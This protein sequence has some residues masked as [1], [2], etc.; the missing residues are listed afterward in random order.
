MCIL[1]YACEKDQESI[2]TQS[3]LY[4][5]D[6]E[7]DKI[8]IIKTDRETSSSKNQRK[9]L[10]S[11]SNYQPQVSGC[12]V[13]YPVLF[14]EPAFWDFGDGTSSSASSSGFVHTYSGNGT[15]SISSSSGARFTVIID[16]CNGG[17]T[18][19]I[20]VVHHTQQGNCFYNAEGIYSPNGMTQTYKI[21]GLIPSSVSNISF[22]LFND[23]YVRSF[24]PYQM[25]GTYFFD[26]I[27][28]GYP[29]LR[30]RGNIN[31]QQGTLYSATI[32]LNNQCC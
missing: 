11:S 23:N 4:T 21:S 20:N 24:E 9:M 7:A 32:P 26:F 1:L 13:R 19:P 18:I 10:G 16:Q 6:F 25:N 17:F 2:I 15:Y 3:K 14:G 31:G 22:E 28:C 5:A 12:L 30:I 8:D 27:G 29:T